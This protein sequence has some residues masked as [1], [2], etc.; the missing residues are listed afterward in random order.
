MAGPGGQKLMTPA[1]PGVPLLSAYIATTAKRVASVSRTI[2][3]MHVHLSKLRR[4][5][6]NQ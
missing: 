3:L 2:K 5:K 4:A 1:A 6:A